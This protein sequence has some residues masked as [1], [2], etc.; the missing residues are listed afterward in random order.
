M[1]D[2]FVANSFQSLALLLVREVA[3]STGAAEIEPFGFS[4]GTHEAFL[5]GVL[6]RGGSSVEVYLYCDEAG[7]SSAKSHWRIFEKPDYESERALLKAFGA[8]LRVD[9]LTS[10]D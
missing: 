1:T 8:A 2:E 10:S 3:A 6:E 5:R 9:L 4:R 7:F